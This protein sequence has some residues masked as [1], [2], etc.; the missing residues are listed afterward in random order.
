MNKAPTALIADDEPLLREALARQLAQAWPALEIV[1][2][3]HNGREAIRQFDAAGPTS[4]FS[5]STCPA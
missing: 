2:F 5:T 1:A 4:V 3:A